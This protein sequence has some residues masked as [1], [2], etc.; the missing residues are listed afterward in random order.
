MPADER[1]KKFI[2]TL[3]PLIFTPLLGR[4]YTDI[5]NLLDKARNIQ[6]M[7]KNIVVNFSKQEKFGISRSNWVAR[8]STRGFAGS[9]GLARPAAGSTDAKRL[10]GS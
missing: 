9:A 8:G 4:Y 2:H 7:K 6:D 1:I 5:I 10:C 3:Q